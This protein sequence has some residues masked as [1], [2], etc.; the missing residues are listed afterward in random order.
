MYVFNRKPKIATL[1]SFAPEE[2]GNDNDDRQAFYAGG[3]ETR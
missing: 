2:E 3:S 1:A